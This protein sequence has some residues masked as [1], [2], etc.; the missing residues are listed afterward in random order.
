MQKIKLYKMLQSLDKAEFSRLSKFL[1]S[2][3]F[4]HT[5][6]FVAY[7]EHLK[8]FYPVFESPKLSHEN[9]WAKVFPNQ[10]Y[11]EIKCRRLL[12][13]F[14]KLVRE[15]L[16]IL[17]LEKQKSEKR[18]LFIKSLGERN[19]FSLFEKETQNYLSEIEELPFRDLEYHEAITALNFDYFFHPLT[20]KHTLSDDALVQLM[21]GIDKKFI[22]EKYRIGSEMKNRERI[23]AKQYDLRFL[24]AVEEETKNGFFLEN[25]PFELYRLLFE[26]YDEKKAASA[27]DNLKMLLIDQI[28][29]LRRLDQS[30]FLTQL[31]NYA[32]R[33]LN[34]GR[35]KFYGEALDLYKLALEN[36]L[37]VENERIEEAVFRNIVNIA[38]HE[39]QFE[40]TENFI[41]YYQKYLDVNNRT[42]V[43]EHSTGLWYFFQNDFEQ[44]YFKFSN[45][46]FSQAYQPSARANLIRAL[47]EMFLLDGSLYDLL[48]S[49]IEAFEK[50]LHR[51]ELI[52]SYHKEAHLN[53]NFIVKKLASGIFQ[54]KDIK[55]LKKSVFENIQRREKIVGKG[56]LM[57]KVE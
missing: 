7:Y 36:E 17:Q 25:K 30:L 55:K 10:A 42:D 24:E 50:Y 14:T 19:L 33:Q 37:V 48:I 13:D 8:K 41:E 57:K 4:N 27:F 52:S 45:H 16:T 51:N 23:L 3:F 44:A 35:D 2:P 29:N 28:R 9:I 49:Q 22:L 21:N 56:W 53:F 47:Y 20:Q 54:V 11:H 38:C 6:S 26:M 31:I 5:Q 18:K 40:W 43:V 34:S 15:Y 1:R 32:V 39:N 12:S 46:S